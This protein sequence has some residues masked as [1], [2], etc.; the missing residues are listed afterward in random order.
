MRC[1]TPE[2]TMTWPKPDT[3][4][5][6]SQ[7]H[8]QGP[9]H[10]LQKEFSML[11]RNFKVQ[12]NFAFWATFPSPWSKMRCTIRGADVALCACLP[13]IFGFSASTWRNWSRRCQVPS[14]RSHLFFALYLTLPL[15]RRTPILLPF[16]TYSRGPCAQPRVSGHRQPM[17]WVARAILLSVGGRGRF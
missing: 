9:N 5:V 10:F 15:I 13:P 7:N 16:P 4:K 8:P 11:L 1:I 12:C 14:T 6:Q 3:N 2:T 17:R